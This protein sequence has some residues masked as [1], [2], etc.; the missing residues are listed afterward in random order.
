MLHPALTGALAGA[1]VDDRHRAAARRHTIRL[2][3]RAARGPHVAA[4]PTAIERSA[5]DSAAWTSSAPAAGMTPT[6]TAHAAP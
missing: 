1:H 2:A 4:T 3:H 5:S 6:E